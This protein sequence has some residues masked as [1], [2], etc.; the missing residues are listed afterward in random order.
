MSAGARELCAGADPAREL[1]LAR[2]E[3]IL[4]SW[5]GR[6]ASAAT[7]AVLGTI[8]TATAAVM[9]VAAT[10]TLFRKRRFYTEVMTRWL[11]LTFLRIAG[12]ELVLR[13]GGDFPRKQVMYV[14]NHPSSLDMF[15]LLAL[16][17]PD[18][19]Y[20]LS[21]E[22]RRI[23][24]LGVIATLMETIFTPPQ[25]LPQERALCFQ[26]AEAILRRTGSSVCLSPEGARVPG[27]RVGPFNKGVF[28]LATN[29]KVPIVPLVIEIPPES[30]PG[31]GWQVLPGR[32]YLHVLPEID[33][34]EW[35]LEDLDRN[36][37]LVRSV[38][39][40]F[41]ERLAAGAAG[42]GVAP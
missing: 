39:Q 34:T 33:T 7:I 28:H 35:S 21:R 31:K 38:Y 3:R 27:G 17:L 6:L 24:P 14:F 41:Q 5:R 16:G 1:A 23:V 12:I 10:C 11:S 15:V 8:L 40:E 30:D 22:C 9:L 42:A 18:T 32:V 13:P 26:R 19:R 2:R 36:R 20:F 4:G 25:S 29:L 37:A